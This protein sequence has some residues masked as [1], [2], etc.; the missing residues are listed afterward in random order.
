M[1]G[2]QCY[3]G[4]WPVESAWESLT[5]IQGIQPKLPNP[6]HLFRLSLTAVIS[7]FCHNSHHERLLYH[8]C[9]RGSPSSLTVL[10]E[11]LSPCRCTPMNLLPS[12][13]EEAF[14]HG[15]P[16]RGSP[17]FSHSTPCERLPILTVFMDIR[18][19]GFSPRLSSLQ[20]LRSLTSLFLW[21]F[22]ALNNLGFKYWI[23]DFLLSLILFPDIRT[24]FASKILTPPNPTRIVFSM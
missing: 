19:W 18:S 15:C 11:S 23:K 14:H 9:Y 5:R 24:Y 4:H 3:R 8:E 2:S 6:L 17:I 22:K 1:V 12:L 10:Y 21:V 16:G 20:E 7:V 13:V